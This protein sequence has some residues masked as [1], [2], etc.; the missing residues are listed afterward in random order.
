MLYGLLVV[1][2]QLAQGHTHQPMV[3]QEV[4]MPATDCNNT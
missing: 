2:R 3:E 1:H 4:A